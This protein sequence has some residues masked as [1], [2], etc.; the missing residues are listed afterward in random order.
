MRLKLMLVV[1]GLGS[2]AVAAA[3]GCALVLGLDEFVDAPPDAGTTATDAVCDPGDSQPC[4]GGPEGTDGVGLCRAGQ[5]TYVDGPWAGACEGEVTPRAEDCGS[6][7]RRGL[8]RHRLQRPHLGKAF[9]RTLGARPAQ[10]SQ[11][12]RKATSWSPG[13][14]T[15]PSASGENPSYRQVRSISS[16][17]SSIL[18]GKRSGASASVTRSIKR[19][20]PLMGTATSSSQARSTAR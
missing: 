17:R 14:S 1:A 10:A 8:R 15:R 12:T 4:Y 11:S 5:R 6:A 2:G 13:T 20:W 19:R 7:G 3:G 16:W 18:R 9:R